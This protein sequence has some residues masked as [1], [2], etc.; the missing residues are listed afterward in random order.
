MR[1]NGS[2]PVSRAGKGVSGGRAVF[3]FDRPSVPSVIA[4]LALAGLLAWIASLVL[5]KNTC[6]AI[7]G[8]L[9]WS[10]PALTSPTT[11]NL[12]TGEQAGAS[13]V[14]LD[15][16]KDYILRMPSTPKQGALWIGGGRN[17]VIIGGEFAPTRFTDLAGDNIV[18]KLYKQVGTVHIEGLKFSNPNSLEFDAIAIDAP[19]AIVQIE[20]VRVDTLLGSQATNHSDLVQPYG[21]AKELRIDHFT[22]QSALQGLFLLNNKYD[23][24]CGPYGPVRLSNINIRQMEPQ[25]DGRYML[26]FANSS[27]APNFAGQVHLSNVY[28]SALPQYSPAGS[29]GMMPRVGMSAPYGAIRYDTNKVH[30]PNWRSADG[31]LAINGFISE[32]DPATGDFVPAGVAGYNYVSPGYASGD[33]GTTTPTTSTASFLPQADASVNQSYAGTNYGTAKGLLVDSSPQRMNSYLRFS[34]SGVSGTV[35][36]AKLRL[37]AYDGSSDGPALYSTGSSWSETGITWNNRPAVSGSALGDK[38]SVSDGAWV[39]Y[40]VTP[41]V[42]GK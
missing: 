6:A 15:N 17:V 24:A 5:T 13:S 38:G 28:I 14:N 33:G 4:T 8:K 41:T 1:S 12:T 9:R 18:L 23:T 37:Y 36:G 34:V 29:Y 35:R 19:Q 39:E 16:T 32:G 3:A 31:S 2:I 7:G 20:N 21:G 25:T 30:W 42:K 27:E 40:D 10:P 11:I 22:G 26:Y